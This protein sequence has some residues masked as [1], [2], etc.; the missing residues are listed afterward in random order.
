MK[1]SSERLPKETKKVFSTQEAVP[2]P[3]KK[4]KLEILMLLP[5]TIPGYTYSF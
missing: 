3:V 4:G 2:V 1:K 5:E